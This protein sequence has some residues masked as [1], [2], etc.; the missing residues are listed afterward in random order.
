MPGVST[1]RDSFARTDCSDA[2]EPYSLSDF[3]AVQNP[4][5]PQA[6]IM[7]GLAV[8]LSTDVPTNIG[9]QDEILLVTAQDLVCWQNAPSIMTAFDQSA[10]ATGQLVIA[11]RGYVASPGGNRRPEG[12]GI[13]TGSDLAAPAG[14]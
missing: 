7:P 3:D 1:R 2:T 13:I 6:V 8:I 10:V 14:F 5:R 11:A 9:G 4:S 12:V